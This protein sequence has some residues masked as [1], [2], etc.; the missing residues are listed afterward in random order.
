MAGVSVS[1]W[2]WPRAEWKAASTPS[3]PPMAQ[4]TWLVALSMPRI[5]TG[6]SRLQPAV[7][8]TGDAIGPR[9]PRG[10]RAAHAD[11]ALVVSLA[12]RELD[13]EELRRERWRHDVAP[14]DERDAFVVER[15]AQAEVEQLLQ[16]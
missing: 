14:F 9:G 11:D 12:E 10:T 3:W 15:L 13:L 16:V 6:W 5:S 8:G 7:E 4:P 1:A 2:R